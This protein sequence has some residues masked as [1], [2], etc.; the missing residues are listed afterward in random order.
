MTFPRPRLGQLPM[1][2]R[3]ISSILME[4]SRPGLRQSVWFAVHPTA[5]VCGSGFL[6]EQ[7]PSK[8]QTRDGTN[9][10]EGL[11][12]MRG[13]KKLQVT[14]QRSRTGHE[15]AIICPSLGP[16][17]RGLGDYRCPLSLPKC[18]GLDNEQCESPGCGKQQTLDGPSA[19]AGKV[20][21]S[22]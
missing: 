18:P 5:C 8:S 16:P 22:S 21:C 19:V 3:V 1:S 20:P 14:T 9:G 13:Q 7:S 11:S 6:E 15:G 17:P 2:G 4:A 10:K 12:I